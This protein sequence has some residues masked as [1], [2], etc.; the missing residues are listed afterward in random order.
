MNNPKMQKCKPRRVLHIIAGMSP[1]GAENWLIKLLRKA[2]RNILQMDFCVARPE[3]GLYEEEITSLG[4]K[5][6]RCELKPFLTYQHRL[7]RIL[8][9]NEYDVVHS[10]GWLFSG[11]I[12]KVADNSN[13][14]VRIAYS[15][16][17]HDEHSATLYRKLYGRLMR[18]MIIKHATHCLG[19]C[20][21]AASA[22]FGKECKQIDKCGVLYTSVDVEAFRPSQKPSVTKADFGIPSDA[23]VIGHVGSFRL[24]K[25]HTF[26]LEIAVE[27]IKRQPKAYIFLAGEGNLRPEA[28]AKAERLGISKRIIF[29][30]NRKDVPQLMMHL[31]DVLLF[32]SIYEGMPLTMVEAVTAGLRVVCSDVISREASEVLPEVFTHLSLDLPA[33]QWAE[34]VIEI[35]NEA[36][37]PH[38]YAYNQVKNS[39]FA[40]DYSLRE[41]SKIYGC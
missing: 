12:L 1:G 33:T 11:I 4:S 7:S 39:H 37:P 27:I 6:I 5:I 24:A 14:P 31:F 30:G 32:P 35:L 25:N 2:D 19:C 16:T 41:L 22:L 28:E 20:S 38:K 21:E 8:R 15:H 26:L 40:V 17:T 29:A 10:H 23:L 36:K 3:E 34:K 18:R 13:V 9:E